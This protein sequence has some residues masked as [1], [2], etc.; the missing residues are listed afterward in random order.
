[1][2]KTNHING[3]PL[4]YARLTNHPYG[5]RGEQRNFWVETDF[6]KKLETAF[7]EI[8]EK[9]PYGV[10]EAITTAGIFVDKAGQH[11][12]GTA[13]DLD[14]IFWANE[15]LVTMNYVHQK[16]LY[17]GIE[18]FLRKHFGLVLNY[19]YPHH[20]DHWHIDISVP[21]DFNE[22]SK[23][24]TLY[25]QMAM[26]HI[27]GKDIIIDGVWGRQT[28]GMVNEVFEKLNIATPITTKKNY[29]KFLDA[30]GNI[31]FK[32]CD[33]RNSPIDLLDNLTDVIEILPVQY[34]TQ[35]MQALNSFLDHDDTSS[36]LGDMDQHNDHDSDNIIN[37]Y[38]T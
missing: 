6:Y 33:N 18:S 28:R 21:V 9:C 19:L 13:F 31:A 4:H 23:S 15:S 5:T 24:E 37:H 22:S 17:I 38:T 26:K 11:G 25:V 1:M 8:F 32:M 7:E 20:E 29:L 27:Y 16:V 2:K 35:V 30:T 12:H 3:I 14:A 36:W 10:P 34:R